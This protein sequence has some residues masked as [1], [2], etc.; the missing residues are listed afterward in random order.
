[1]LWTPG[2]A[3]NW[4]VDNF[5]ATY[6]DAGFGVNS[7]GH[8]NAN[9]KGA[10]TNMLNGIAEDCYGMA[11]CFTGNNVTGT[12]KRSLTDILIDPDAGVGNAGSSWSVLINN[13][14]SAYAALGCGGYWYYFPV[15]LKAGTAIGSAHQD[16][17]AGTVALRVGI[18]VFGKPTRPEL[19]RVG[20]KIETFGAVTG[21][22]T[23]SSITPGTNAMGAWTGTLGTTSNAL[24]WWQG[25][26]GY[27][28]ATIGGGTNISESTLLDIS[29]SQDAGTTKT[30][31]AEN[32]M[33]NFSATEQGGKAAF[34]SR[35]PY[36]D[37]PAG[38]TV[39]M[40]AASSIAPNTTPT[41][42]AYGLGA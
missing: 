14:Y 30:I 12:T 22:T 25:G 31:V 20:T 10:N 26:L 34:G 18:K 33:A 29:V 2:C 21:T 42:V 1:M 36:Y 8:A 3:F 27:N 40:R 16:L 15:Y 32:I 6:S 39:Y 5:G 11:I 23:G 37:A 41:V 13:L 19:L 7:P 38:S 9:T 4:S 35:L 28:D 17:V 24:F